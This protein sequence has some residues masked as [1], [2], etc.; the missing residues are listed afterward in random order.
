VEGFKKASFSEKILPNEEV[1][2]RQFLV[3]R[4][5]IVMEMKGWRFLLKPGGLELAFL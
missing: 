5:N 1:Y 3:G 4:R 2:S